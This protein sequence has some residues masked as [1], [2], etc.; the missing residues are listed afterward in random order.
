M[1]IKPQS[2]IDGANYEG[3][4]KQLAKKRAK[5]ASL[6][7]EKSNVSSLLMNNNVSFIKSQRQTEQSVEVDK[8]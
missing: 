6:M 1:L 8:R 5:K 4:S 7:S 3:R 2:Q